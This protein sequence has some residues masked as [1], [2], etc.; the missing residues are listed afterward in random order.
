ML[1]M[2]VSIVNRAQGAQYHV[3]AAVVEA[4]H[5]NLILVG[6]IRVIQKRINRSEVVMHSRQGKSQVSKR[7]Q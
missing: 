1:E 3:N 6:Y 5:H 2:C 4:L 7:E